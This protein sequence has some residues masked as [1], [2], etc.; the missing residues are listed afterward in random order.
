[1]RVVLADDATLLREGLA[2]VLAGAG[3]RVAAQVGTAADLLS[4]VD[5]SRPDVAVVDIRMPPT[6]S[7]DG[8]IAAQQDRNAPR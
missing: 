1:M 5:E 2:R 8:L 3:I 6:F 4:V 7:D